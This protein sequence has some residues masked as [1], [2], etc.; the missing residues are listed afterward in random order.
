MGGGFPSACQSPAGSRE[1]PR[2][3]GSSRE[4]GSDSG[5]SPL[6]AH[7]GPLNAWCTAPLQ[8]PLQER[9]GCSP[10]ASPRPQRLPGGGDPLVCSLPALRPASSR[11]TPAGFSHGSGSL[12]PGALGGLVASQPQSQQACSWSQVWGL[13]GTKHQSFTRGAY[14]QSCAQAPSAKALLEDH[15]PGA[16]VGDLTLDN[17]GL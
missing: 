5:P 14:A 7:G 16:A 13:L 4:R 9:Q 1:G 2:A 17:L 11:T 6:H 3:A 12:F 15:L 8:G 10:Q